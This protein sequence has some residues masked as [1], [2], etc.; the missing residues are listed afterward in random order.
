MSDSFLR[1]IPQEPDFLPSEEATQAIVSAMRS[2]VSA[3]SS[4]KSKQFPGIQFV[5]Q[6]G[7]FERVLC[8]NC[9]RDV[10]DQW[11]AWM[12]ES[13]KSG[14]SS[15]SVGFTCCGMETDLN[16]LIYQWPAGFSRFVLEIVSPNPSG[17]LAEGDQCRIEAILGCRIRQ[18]LAHY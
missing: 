5:D 1:I 16:D 15:R 17:W 7:N 14:F 12:T 18:I 9:Q 4:I 6:G 2:L 8:P 11:P 10:T 3:Q 13:A